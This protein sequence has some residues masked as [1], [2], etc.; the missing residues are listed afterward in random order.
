LG[1]LPWSQH[2]DQFALAPNAHPNDALTLDHILPFHPVLK[3]LENWTPGSSHYLSFPLLCWVAPVV[4][5]W[6]H[7][8][9]PSYIQSHQIVAVFPCWACTW[10]NMHKINM[11]T[12]SKLPC[13]KQNADTYPN[14]SYEINAQ[15]TRKCAK[16]VFQLLW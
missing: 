11:C 4:A 8:L 12:L 6:I 7:G 10:E 14:H 3:C 15:L 2:G 5:L 13:S 1:V 9:S 16:L